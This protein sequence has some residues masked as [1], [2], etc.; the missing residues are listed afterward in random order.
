VASCRPSFRE[1]LLILLGNPE[2][3]LSIPAGTL[4]TH[5]LAGVLGSPLDAGE[6]LYRDLRDRYLQMDD[7]YQELD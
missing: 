1:L 5:H 6:S 4:G 2:Q 7:D 3:V